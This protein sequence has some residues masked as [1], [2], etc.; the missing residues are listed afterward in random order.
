MAA[1]AAITESSNA[2]KLRFAEAFVRSKNA[3]TAALSIFSSP[4]EA[5]TQSNILPFDPLVIE[6][7]KRLTEEIGED[8]L[9][10]SKA[11]LAMAILKRA[12]GATDN[13]EYVKLMKLHCD[14]RGLIDKPGTNVDVNVQ[15]AP[16][17][18]MRDHGTDEEWQA[19][20]SAQQSKLVID[21]T[22]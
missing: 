13:E 14:I 20:V 18:V 22:H 21:A 17:M 15:L 1:H 19:K 5:L 11:S 3:A 6:E 2:T 10:P 4:S 12:E 8:G 16:V 9:M 7:V